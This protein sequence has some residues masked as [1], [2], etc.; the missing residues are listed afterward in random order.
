MTSTVYSSQE[1]EEPKNLLSQLQAPRRYH[2]FAFVR[3][4]EAVN[5]EG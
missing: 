1:R 3:W 5:E 2:P 4:G